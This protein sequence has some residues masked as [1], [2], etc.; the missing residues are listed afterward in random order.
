MYVCCD[1]AAIECGLILRFDLYLCIFI[2]LRMA[3]EVITCETLKDN[4]YDFKAD[5]WSLGI[6]N[7]SHH[8]ISIA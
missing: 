7:I 2:L 3:P 5:I 4:P 1:Y 8:N 6:I